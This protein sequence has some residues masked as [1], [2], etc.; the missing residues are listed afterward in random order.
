[1]TVSAKN[2]KLIESADMTK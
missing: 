1:V 2:Y